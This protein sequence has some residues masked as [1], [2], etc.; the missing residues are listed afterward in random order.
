VTRHANCAFDCGD[1]VTFD[2]TPATS[3][4]SSQ[5]LSADADTTFDDRWQRPAGI[6]D[7]IAGA[8]VAAERV[9]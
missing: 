6:I 2:P 7:Q 3:R 4:S 8:L 1:V 9:A 5:H